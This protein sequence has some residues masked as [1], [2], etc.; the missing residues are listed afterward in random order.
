M[1][2]NEL[3]GYNPG[4]SENRLRDKH[5]AVKGDFQSNNMNSARSSVRIERRFP[6]P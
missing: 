6:K 3:K 2:D 1:D 4:N 5:I